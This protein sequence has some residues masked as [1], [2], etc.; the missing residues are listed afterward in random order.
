[1]ASITLT[2]TE[3][4]VFGIGVLESYQH[5]DYFQEDW[6]LF[7]GMTAGEVVNV[8]VMQEGEATNLADGSAHTSGTAQMI[9]TE[10]PLVDPIKSFV[11]ILKTQVDVRPDL[12]LLTTVGRQVGRD[13]GFGRTLR[14]A[15]HLAFTADANSNSDVRDYV[16]SSTLADNTIAGIKRVAE[17]MDEDGVDSE[18]RFCMLKPSLFYALRGAAEV[19]SSDFTQGQNI[20]QAIGGNM[21]ILNYLNFTIRNMGGIFGV[22]WTA[23]SHGP[24]N[25]PTTTGAEMA[26]DMSAVVGIFWQHDSW[27]ARHQTGLETNVDW[28]HRDQVWMPIARL[29]MGVKVI[30]IDGLWILTDNSA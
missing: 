1:M 18:M 28:I 12:N 16:T 5:R 25:L 9:G 27:A 22:D 30:K 11:D 2:D 21:S 19:I 6:A 23:S 15:N 10:I 4:E 17:E 3:L 24:K 20:N 7:Q 14:I 29:H 26:F 13:V 8:T